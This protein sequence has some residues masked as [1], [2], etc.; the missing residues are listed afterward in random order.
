M[1]LIRKKVHLAML[2]F[3]TI[4]VVNTSASGGTHGAP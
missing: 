1:L 3:L 2:D 4:V